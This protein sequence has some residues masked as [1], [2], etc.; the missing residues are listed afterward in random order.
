VGV[1]VLAVPVGIMLLVLIPALRKRKTYKAGRRAE[2]GRR[3]AGDTALGSAQAVS[4]PSGYSGSALLKALAVD[5]EGF[6]PTGDGLPYNEGWAGTMLGL[7]ARM[8][9]ATKLLEAHFFYGTRASGQVFIRVG[10][11]E[12]IAGG[13]TMLSN[14]HVRAITVLR[15]TAP[16]FQIDSDHGTLV[17]SDASPA[18]VRGLVGALTPDRVTWSDMRM[19]GGPDGIVAA[20]TA[21]DGIENSFVF[22]LWLAEH[23]AAA[24]RL[25]ALPPARLGPSWKVP[26]GL[27]HSFEPELPAGGATSR[28]S[29]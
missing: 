19:T 13:T 14:R 6:G 22:D 25:P 20:R 7:K 4:D 1:Y 27:G 26:Y 5:N 12:K 24:L 10:P 3:Q 16:A 17:A 23:L 8:S 28:A 11:D 18:E 29:P 21:I 9:S 2:R 15:V